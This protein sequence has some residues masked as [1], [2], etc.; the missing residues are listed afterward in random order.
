MFFSKEQIE[1]SV[2]RLNDLNPFFGTTFLAFKQ[3]DLPTGA[4]KS[5]N[6]TA[7]LDTFLQN[8]YHPLDDY[9][10]FY[11]PFK[12]WDN[13]KKRWN[14]PLYSRSLH[15]TA[16]QHFKDVLI[17]EG[18]GKW[19]WQPDYIQA[20]TTKYL[21]NQLIPAFDLAVWLY[22]SRQWQDGLQGKDVIEVL[23]AEFSLEKERELFDAD[24]P[25]LARPWLLEKPISNEALLDI[26]SIP[27]GKVTEGALLRVLRLTEVGPAKKIEMNLAP[28]LNLITGDNALGKTFLLE[29]AWWALTG[30]WIDYPARPRQDATTPNIAFQISRQSLNTRAQTAKY[31]WDQLTWDIP[32]KRNNLPGLSIFAQIDGSFAVWDPAKYILAREEHYAGRVTDAFTQFSRTSIL[33]GLHEPDRY[34]SQQRTAGLINDWIRWQEAADQTRFEELSAALYTL[35]PHP[36]RE[37]LVPGKPGRVPELKDSRDIPTLEF[38]YGDVPITHCSAGVQRIVSL[39]YL[40]IWAWQ[41]HVKTAES[42]RRSPAQ[43]IVLLVDEMEAHLHP[44]WQRTILPAVMNAVQEIASEVQIQVLVVTHSPLVL[45][46]AEPI[47][48]SGQDKLFHLYLENNSVQLDDVPFVKRGQA[49]R[50]LM[51]DLFGMEQTRSIEAETAIDTA[52]K[53]QLKENA[54]KEEVQRAFDNLTRFLA[55][56]DEYWP[57]WTYFAQEK[58]VRFDPRRKT[59]GTSPLF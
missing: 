3:Q 20:I 44:L 1:Q 25:P 30:D 58:G 43:S 13:K 29:C 16:S 14:S 32:S 46:S 7:T 48:D 57:L 15:V 56:D 33:H 19:G 8:Y 12:T 41:E 10:G 59:I 23:F 50:W 31:K 49:D 17:H 39:A 6:S 11:T 36:D 47:F 21:R 51:S 38:P 52:N 55:P 26:T 5:I 22:H 54:T 27:P 37:L 24:V 35:S 28:R 40:L 9:P 34:G 18:G 53:L 42:M 2:K 4:T 45:A